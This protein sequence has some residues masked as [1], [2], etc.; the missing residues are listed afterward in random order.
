MS[1]MTASPFFPIRRAVALGALCMSGALVAV[2]GSAQGDTLDLDVT[3]VGNREM[4]LQDAHKLLIWPSI[5]DMGVEKPVFNYELLPKRMMVAP[6][7]ERVEAKRVDVS[8][9]LPLLYRGYARLGFGMYTSPIAELAYTDLRSRKSSWGLHGTHR[10][11]NGGFEVNDSLPQRF[12]NSELTAWAKR[13]WKRETLTMS[14]FAGQQGLSYLGLDSAVAVP[15]EAETS[16]RDRFGRWGLDLR[17]ESTRKDS[18]DWQVTAMLGYRHLWNTGTVREHSVLTQGEAA[19]YRDGLEVAMIWD[20]VFNA[21]SVDSITSARQVLIKAQPQVTKQ[22][23]ALR[24]TLGAAIVVDARGTR[25]FQVFPLAEA[26]LQVFK[27][28]LVPYARISGGVDNNRLRTSIETNPYVNPELELRNTYRRFDFRSGVRGHVTSHF[29]YH[30]RLSVE[31]FEQYMFFVNDSNALGGE[32]FVPLYDTLTVTTLGGDARLQVSE[33]FNLWGGVDLM[34]Y[35]TPQLEAWNLPNMVWRAGFHYNW[36][37]KVSLQADVE[38]VGGRAGASLSPTATGE[39][40]RLGSVMGMQR[41]LAAFADVNLK[42]EYHYNKRM[43]AWFTASNLA[44]ARYA[45]WNNY[46]VQ[47]FLARFGASYAF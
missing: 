15:S 37:D 10:S 12:S 43:S 26:S 25:P 47:G 20:G 1:T 5:R 9:P 31:H 14:G 22:S 39:E 23:G 42:M 3:F 38:V 35:R 2:N 24:S 18:A 41:E 40:A 29:H 45:L 19:T 36:H 34:S 27:G 7:F 4:L 13:F 17:S 11:S 33:Q 6:E 44:G 30:A 8:T 21:H 28:I 46:P 16:L 32:R